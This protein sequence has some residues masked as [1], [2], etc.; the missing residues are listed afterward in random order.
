MDENHALIEAELGLGSPLRERDQISDSMDSR[1]QHLKI[2]GCENRK[3]E[4]QLSIE[5]PLIKERKVEGTRGVDW[6][7]DKGKR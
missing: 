7:G 1:Y 3:G 2:E 6:V 5:D 4:L